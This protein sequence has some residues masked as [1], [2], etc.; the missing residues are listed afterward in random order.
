MPDA[1]R[2]STTANPHAADDDVRVAIYHHF[3]EH[4]TPPSTADAARRLGIPEGDTRAA[5]ERLAASHTIVLRPGTIDILMAA[6]LSAVPTPFRVT[7]ADGRRYWAN[8]VWDSLGVA[9]MLG[10]DATV[11]TACPDCDDAMRL[12]VR[13]GELVEREG[14]VHFAVPAARWWQDIVFT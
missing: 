9:A 12:E 7:V 10:A 13:G 2:G 4:G 1:V 3:V 6:P 14:V 5:Y 11:E 8:C